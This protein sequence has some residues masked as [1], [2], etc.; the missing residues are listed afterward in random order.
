MKRL[1][2]VTVYKPSIY[3]THIDSLFN[4]ASGKKL[5]SNL[6]HMPEKTYHFGADGHTHDES[7]INSHELQPLNLSETLS[8]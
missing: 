4:Q 7:S 5:A 8:W 6:L 3:E 2:A 1:P